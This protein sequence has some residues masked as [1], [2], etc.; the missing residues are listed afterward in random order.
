MNI[1]ISRYSL[2]EH[3]LDGILYIDGVRF[4]ET[5]EN[6]LTAIPS[7]IYPVVRHYCHQFSRYTP[8]ILSSGSLPDCS[9][10]HKLS[11]VCCNTTLP[12]VCHQLIAGNGVFNRTDGTIIMGTRIVP[13]CLMNSKEPF[14]GLCERLRKLDSRGSQI[15]VTISNDY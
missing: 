1:H 11:N 12:C 5:S 15:T 8:L 3:A 7:G 9:S 4:C 6:S 14:E 10:C 13:G 2:K